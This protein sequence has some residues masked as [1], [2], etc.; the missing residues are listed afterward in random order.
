MI[1]ICIL[2]DIPEIQKGLQLIVEKN[3]NFQLLACF[4]T[5][6]EAIKNIP[7]LKP[8]VVI[9][10]IN[11]PKKT[12]IDCIIEVKRKE[13]NIQFIMFTIYE[14]NNQVFEALKAGASGYILKNT[15]PEKITEAII[16]LYEGGSPMSPKIAR[17]VLLSFNN[18]TSTSVQEI[19]TNREHEVLEL[20][21]RG[22][23]YKEIAE[24]LFISLS[25]VKRHLNHI[26]SKLQVQNKTE[27]VNKL[28]GKS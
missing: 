14:D 28:Y 23:L 25:T 9:T 12:G 10:D 1:R 7:N 6:E 20:L 13:K 21:S 3:S 4:T 5:A 22:F 24:K 26:Y 16:E 15:S 18:N 17:K 11:L 8:D 2:E 27:A 19:L